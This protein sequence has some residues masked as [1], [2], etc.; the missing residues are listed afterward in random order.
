VREY[1]L[2]EREGCQTSVKLRRQL[3]QTAVQAFIDNPFF[4]LEIAPALVRA[5]RYGRDDPQFRRADDVDASVIAIVE[6][7]YLQRG[8]DP[9]LDDPVQRAADQFAS[10]LRPHSRGHAHF[11]IESADGDALLQRLKITAGERDFGQVESRHAT[12][13]A[14]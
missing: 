7:K 9:V 14:G 2:Y 11:P 5:A 8:D 6:A 4:E 10:P 3:P 1:K 13:D 12:S